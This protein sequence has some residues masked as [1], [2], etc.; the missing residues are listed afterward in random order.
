[1]SRRENSTMSL[2]KRFLDAL[3]PP[4]HLIMT[5]S[6]GG[7]QVDVR[8]NGQTVDLAATRQASELPPAV[9]SAFER[10]ARRRNGAYL[11]PFEVARNLALYFRANSDDGFILEPGAILTLREIAM[12]AWFGIHWLLDSKTWRMRR[13]L[14]GADHALG[15]GWFAQQNQVWHVPPNSIPPQL[16]YLLDL[17]ELNSSDGVHLVMELLPVAEANHLPFSA[18]AVVAPPGKLRVEIVKMLERSMD[19]RLIGNPP[20][21]L[22]MLQPVPN[23]TQHL[24]SGN[25]LFPHLGIIPTALLGNLK[26]GDSVRITGEDVPALV[27]DVLRPNAAELGIDLAKLDAQYPILELSKM[28]PWWRLDHTIARGVGRYEAALHFTKGQESL[29]RETVRAKM[30]GT[31]RFVKANRGWIALSYSVIKRLDEIDARLG[32]D[33]VLDGGELLGN[34]SPRLTERQIAVPPL[35]TPTPSDNGEQIIGWLDTVRAHGLP[36]GIAGFS[37][38][39]FTVLTAACQHLLTDY[40]AARIL[41]VA[42]MIRQR[43]IQPALEK[44]FRV[45]TANRTGNYDQTG[46]I[47]LCEAFHPG[48][49]YGM[50]TAVVFENVDAVLPTPDVARWGALSRD[51]TLFAS[52]T[53]PNTWRQDRAHHLMHLLRMNPADYEAFARHCIWEAATLNQP[54]RFG[55]KFTTSFKKFI[56]GEDKPGAPVPQRLVPRASSPSS[57]VLPPNLPPNLPPSVPP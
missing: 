4:V 45:R 11:F 29:A 22:N 7:V 30:R 28:K 39:G 40:D 55:E 6:D 43:M 18:D 46:T 37:D 21:L 19:I 52:M 2:L 31:S 44:A 23:V 17:S 50:W 1:M 12:P 38:F 15:G 27:N 20:A 56:V 24:M 25:L 9:L 36:A 8:Q 35:G 14:H 5:P 34:P 41:W 32:D 54:V 10:A 16:L 3:N 26:K 42:P 51:W 49:S 57:P 33:F 48:L 47:Y 13:H 53:L